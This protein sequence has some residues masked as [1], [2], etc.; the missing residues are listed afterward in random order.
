MTSCM[1]GK[2]CPE[3]HCA[4]SRRIICHWKDCKRNDYPVCSPVRKQIESDKLM[5]NTIENSKATSDQ[6]QKSI[7]DAFEIPLEIHGDCNKIPSL[8]ES[9]NADKNKG[10]FKNHIL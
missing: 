4:S 8:K 2:S 3:S 9:Q 6:I 10:M 5:E 1:S 7:L